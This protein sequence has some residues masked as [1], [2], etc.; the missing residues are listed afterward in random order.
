MRSRCALPPFN[1]SERIDLFR[2]SALTRMVGS[3]NIS[4]VSQT[5][6]QLLA[7]TRWSK[8]SGLTTRSLSYLGYPGPASSIFRT[9]IQIQLRRKLRLS[10]Q[11]FV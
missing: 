6:C 1:R 3:S 8:G 2:D 7:S 9:T 11:D 4:A 10:A 5:S